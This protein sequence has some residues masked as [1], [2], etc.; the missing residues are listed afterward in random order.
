M[1]CARSGRTSTWAT[2]PHVIAMAGVLV[3]I[4]SL[5]Y[6]YQKDKA[7]REATFHLVKTRALADAADLRTTL[8]FVDASIQS[9]FLGDP[10]V[11]EDMVA[12]LRQ[13]QSSVRDSVAG[14]ETMEKRIR[15]LDGSEDLTA[16]RE[17]ATSLE[18]MRIESHALLRNVTKGIKV[19]KREGAR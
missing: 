11:R 19:M 12:G 17:L 4:A 8:Q 14:I 10:H 3:A 7:N 15:S 2:W 5:L 1:C 18:V 6:V 9:F 16:L 13:T